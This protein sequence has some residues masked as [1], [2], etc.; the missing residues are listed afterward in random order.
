MY[1]R[2]LQLRVTNSASSGSEKSVLYSL[3]SKEVCTYWIRCF[4]YRSL[5]HASL[6]RAWTFLVA[7]DKMTFLEGTTVLL[8]LKSSTVIS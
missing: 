3:E 7:I 2:I 8:N 1:T 6:A 4:R 5:R